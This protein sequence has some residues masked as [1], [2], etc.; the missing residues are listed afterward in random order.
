MKKI[1][2]IFFLLI[3]IISSNLCFAQNKYGTFMVNSKGNI[4]GKIPDSLLFV[5]DK[6]STGS[7]LLKNGTQQTGKLNIVTYNQKIWFINEKGDTLV[8]SNN[9]DVTM[10]IAQNTIFKRIRNNF[11]NIIS[12]DGDYSF[13]IIKTLE[14]KDPPKTAAYGGTSETSSVTEISTLTNG[15][16]NI[17][18]L[19]PTHHA[20]YTLSIEP[21][22]LK[23]NSMYFPSKKIFLKVFKKN[24]E[25]ISNYLK[26]NKTDFED[27]H[28][29]MK[30]YQYSV[31][32]EK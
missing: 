15:S 28:Q 10:L 25:E 16:G 14:I 1:T 3:M 6:F 27:A 18:Q 32:L 2:S 30:L 24:K 12:Q 7:I 23:K 21:V 20:P 26:N 8:M 22:L 9:D 29:V 17:Y 11:V 31:S 19:N 4:N 5:M 13:G